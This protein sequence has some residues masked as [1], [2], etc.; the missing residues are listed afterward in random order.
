M[1]TGTGWARSASGAIQFSH[2]TRYVAIPSHPIPILGI[3]DVPRYL[4]WMLKCWRD[5]PI[6]T[7]GMLSRLMS[8]GISRWD[9]NSWMEVMRKDKEKLRTK[10]LGLDK[11][12]HG[13]PRQSTIPCV[14]TGLPH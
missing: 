10:N 11:I 2:G 3:E 13:T 5:G 14:D 7:H 8:C 1:G 4:N 6:T 9:L 12:S